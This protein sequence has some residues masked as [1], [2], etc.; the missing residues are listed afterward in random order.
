MFIGEENMEPFKS[1]KLKFKISAST[2]NLWSPPQ[3]LRGMTNNGGLTFSVGAT[4]SRFTIRTE[5]GI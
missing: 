4:T 5:Q 3:N 1:D 2:I